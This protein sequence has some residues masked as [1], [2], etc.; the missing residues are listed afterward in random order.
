MRGRS[1][2]QEPCVSGRA[3]NKLLRT[4]VSYASVFPDDLPLEV[5][6]V[7]VGVMKRVEEELT[8]LRPENNE[9]AIHFLARWR[10]LTSAGCFIVA[11]VG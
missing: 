8:T 11:I 4:P 3:E 1:Y 9:L 10:G 5:W 6:P 7:M 2:F